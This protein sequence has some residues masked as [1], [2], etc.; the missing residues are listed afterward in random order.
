ME[1]WRGQSNESVN[2][3][4]EQ[5]LSSLFNKEKIH[6]KNKQNKNTKRILR[7]LDCNK[8]YNIYAIWERISETKDK[9]SYMEKTLE[10]IMIG[11]ISNSA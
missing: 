1:E 2:P 5:K 3:N 4:A 10:K 7:D 9:D 11:N 6:W 8:R